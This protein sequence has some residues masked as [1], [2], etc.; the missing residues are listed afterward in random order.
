M[1]GPLAISVTDVVSYLTLIGEHDM[2][3]RS[4]FLRLIQHMDA[5]FFDEV[6]KRREQE[7]GK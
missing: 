6:E 2:D 1:G 5:T 4:K 7:N 3:E